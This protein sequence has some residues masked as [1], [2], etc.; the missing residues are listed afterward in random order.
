DNMGNQCG[1]WTIS[2]QGSSGD[3]T[4][5]TN[6]LQAIHIATGSNSEISYSFDGSG[7]AGADIGVVV[8]GEEPYAEGTGDRTDLSL[9]MEDISAVNNVK[10][11][12]IPVVVIL[13]SG[14][15]MIIESILPICDAF[16]AAWLPGS[17]GLGITDVLFGDYAPSGKL[18][19]SWPRNMGQIPVNVGDLNY[20]PL[21]PYGYGLTY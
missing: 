12:G 5:G 2:W 21:F 17:E 9:N 15:P 18:S 14:R 4:Y 7:A 20:D 8:I 11:A 13:I 1:G 16:V 6:I 19:H 3:I 10:N